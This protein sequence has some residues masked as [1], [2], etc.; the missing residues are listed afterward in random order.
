MIRRLVEPAVL[1]LG[2]IFSASPAYAASSHTIYKPGEFCAKAKL[3]KTTRDGKLTLVCK[4][5]GK[6]DR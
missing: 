3:G 6:Y 4:K 1:S 2:M 5:V